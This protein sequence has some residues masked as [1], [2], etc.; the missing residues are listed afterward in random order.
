MESR[1]R[2]LYSKR[3]ADALL[4]SASSARSTLGEQAE[5][6][7]DQVIAAMAGRGYQLKSRLENGEGVFVRPRDWVGLHVQLPGDL[8][9]DLEAACIERDATKRQL[10]IGAL[11]GFLAGEFQAPA[12]AEDDAA[13]RRRRPEIEPVRPVVEQDE[14]DE[15][16]LG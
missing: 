6:E 10:I 14:N 7:A 3:L 9:R 4:G 12:P 1:V 8:Y 13:D 5:R 15:F 2:R 16:Y 11:R